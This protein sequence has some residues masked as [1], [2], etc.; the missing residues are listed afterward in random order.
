M[1]TF[2]CFFTDLQRPFIELLIQEPSFEIPLK[3]FLVNSL[4]QQD[5]EKFSREVGDVFFRKF[6][7][8]LKLIMSLSLKNFSYEIN[9]KL[10]DIQKFILDFFPRFML[11]TKLQKIRIFNSIRRRGEESGLF[12]KKG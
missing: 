1:C 3:N 12:K 10:P 7:I 9:N 2:H 4:G 5:K 6:F 8:Q 11:L